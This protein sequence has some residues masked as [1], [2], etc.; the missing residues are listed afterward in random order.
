MKGKEV[1]PGVAAIANQDDF[2]EFYRRFTQWHEGVPPTWGDDPEF[3]HLKEAIFYQEVDDLLRVI[4]RGGLGDFAPG[5]NLVNFFGACDPIPDGYNFRGNTWD[6]GR[7]EPGL[8]INGR[9]L[10][11]FYTQRGDDSP[12]NINCLIFQRCDGEA[13]SYH[14]DWEEWDTEEGEKSGVRIGHGAY[15][16]V[17]MHPRAVY[18]IDD[19]LLPPEL[20][21]AHELI[22]AAH[23]VAGSRQTK[24][25][26]VKARWGSN[27]LEFARFLYG[28]RKETSPER[29]ERLE[30]D[31]GERNKLSPE[32]L[33]IYEEELAY[34]EKL[35]AVARLMVRSDPNPSGSGRL[36]GGEDQ[37]L[38]YQPLAEFEE[39][40]T[41][42][43][44]ICKVWISGTVGWQKVGILGADLPQGFVR[45]NRKAQEFVKLLEIN[46]DSMIEAAGLQ[47]YTSAMNWAQGMCRHREISHGICE[48]LIASSMGIKPRESYLPVLSRAAKD[49]MW[50]HLALRAL[51]CARSAIAQD[52][53]K[54]S[55][56]IGTL[57]K[58]LK[59]NGYQGSKIYRD[60]LDYDIDLP[61][62]LR[63][64]VHYVEDRI[65]PD[66]YVPP[67]PCF[68]GVESVAVTTIEPELVPE[69]IKEQARSLAEELAKN[70]GM[71][72]T[73]TVNN[74][75]LYRGKSPL[76]IIPATAGR[77]R[78]ICSPPLS[79]DPPARF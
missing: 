42:G 19:T 47:F 62:W 18:A 65:V 77:G 63:R 56:P 23:H 10:R 5:Q 48:T 24:P 31:P 55:T 53:F 71:G 9:K 29:I 25:S 64:G 60:F 3:L 32:E 76:P 17:S 59:D 11:S 75:R 14:S 79:L 30:R 54:G 57:L 8:G 1:R 49:P 28:A 66:Y 37:E 13:W 58:W 46:K 39:S 12:A 61:N 15:S 74:A 22:H 73:V 72:R 34:L 50:K 69:A 27:F 40:V 6:Y 78:R 36:Q 4:E 44:D 7:N 70:P 26:T 16:I 41:V 33:S 45:S 38:H 20:I 51:P 52:A 21:L 68:G 35:R 2:L 43:N 67:H